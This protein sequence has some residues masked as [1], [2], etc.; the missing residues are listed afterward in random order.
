MFAEKHVSATF[1]ICLLFNVQDCSVKRLVTEDGTDVTRS[2]NIADHFHNFLVN[3]GVIPDSQFSTDTSKI[4]PLVSE[5]FCE[6][7]Y[8]TI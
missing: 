5:N 7:M 4:D 2:K 1:R 6:N 8:R 3:S